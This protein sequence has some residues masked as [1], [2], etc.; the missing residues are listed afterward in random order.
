MV[1]WIFNLGHSLKKLKNLL[2]RKY[3]VQYISLH[4]LYA[5]KDE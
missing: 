2:A 4:I 1:S 5:F 3:N